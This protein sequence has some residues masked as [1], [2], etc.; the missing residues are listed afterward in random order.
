MGPVVV[1]PLRCIF[2]VAPHLPFPRL[3]LPVHPPE[4]YY[5][6]QGIHP[7]VAQ[8]KALSR[9]RPEIITATMAGPRP[10]PRSSSV[11]CRARAMPRVSGSLTFMIIAVRAC[12]RA[13][14][15]PHSSRVYLHAFFATQHDAGGRRRS[16]ITRPKSPTRRRPSPFPRPHHHHRHRPRPPPAL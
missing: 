4:D 6:P 8:K 13:C 15:S 10:L 16:S 14:A 2:R 1:T 3:P 11:V 12:V 5:V 7:A 9:P